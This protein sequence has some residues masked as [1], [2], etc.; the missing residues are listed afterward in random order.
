MIYQTLLLYFLS[1]QH[2]QIKNDIKFDHTETENVVRSKNYFQLFFQEMLIIANTTIILLLDLILIGGSQILNH[3][4]IIQSF[5][6]IEQHR[7]SAML[8]REIL[9]HSFRQADQT[10]NCTSFLGRIYQLFCF[11]LLRRIVCYFQVVG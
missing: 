2:S 5:L 10:C 3:L 4:K 11:L 7:I 9:H 8:M 6:L 1:L